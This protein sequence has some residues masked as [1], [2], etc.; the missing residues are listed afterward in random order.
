MQLSMQGKRLFFAVQ[1]MNGVK[2]M[3][4]TPGA[5][6]KLVQQ[7]LKFPSDEG[8]DDFADCASQVAAAVQTGYLADALP[9]PK[10]RR[11]WLQELNQPQ[12]PLGNGQN[13]GSNFCS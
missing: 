10:S 3:Q 2:E 9:V 7:L 11:N 1:D 5:Y 12:E 4:G 6:H 8:H 13:D